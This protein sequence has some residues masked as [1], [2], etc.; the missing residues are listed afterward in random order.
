LIGPAQHW[1]EELLLEAVL[2]QDH[3]FEHHIDCL[4]FVMMNLQQKV[5]VDGPVAK[6]F[7]GENMKVF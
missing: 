1:E 5:F 4:G 2:E 6:F 7:T 3:T